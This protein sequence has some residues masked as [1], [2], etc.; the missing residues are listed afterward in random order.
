[1]RLQG[2]L[3]L[4]TLGSKGV[5]TNLPWVLKT[6]MSATDSVSPPIRVFPSSSTRADSSDLVLQWTSQR[7]AICAM[8]IPF[9][10]LLFSLLSRLRAQFLLS[11]INVVLKPKRHI[12]TNYFFLHFFFKSSCQLFECLWE[13]KDGRKR[14]KNLIP[15]RERG[16]IRNTGR[17]LR[18]EFFASSR[19]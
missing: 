8:M 12:Y 5:N 14:I 18:A 9:W 17:T 2:K 4:I 6:S 1:M 10:I 16:C 3:K 13:N 7:W 15:P 11:V 19:T